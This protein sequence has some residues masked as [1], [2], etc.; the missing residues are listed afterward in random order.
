MKIAILNDTHCG[1]RNSS[2]IFLDNAEKFYGDVF[3]PYLL[4]NGIR[5]IVHLGDYYDNRKSINF[6]AYNRNRI[7]FLGPLRDHGIKMDIVCGNH[8]T[9]FKNTSVLNSLEEM[10][11]H[12]TNEVNIIREPTVMQYGSLRMGLVPWIDDENQERSMDFLANANCD[13]IGGHFDIVGFEMLKGVECEHGLDREVFRRYEKVLSGHFHT[14]SE[15]E[16]ITYLGSQLEFTWSDAHDDKFFH[17]V[18]TETREMTAIRN[19]HTLHYRIYYDD[20]DKDCQVLNLDG[21][22]GK[23]VK[24]QVINKSDQGAFDRFIE[25]ITSRPILDLKIAESFDAFSGSSVSDDNISV[26]D[27]PTLVNTYIDSVD[28]E[29]DKTEIKK[30]MNNLMVEAQVSEFV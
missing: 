5:H 17:V 19:P 29:L 16:N 4:E 8:D 18:D 3:F 27:T 15:Q 11:S 10:L 9:Y 13:W 6:R 21:V 14:K 12:Y 22:D 25:R 2:D 28:T 20:H 30:R 26:D 1:I 7:H 24:V 23:F